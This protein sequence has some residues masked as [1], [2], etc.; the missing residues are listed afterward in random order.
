MTVC[1]TREHHKIR[2]CVSDSGPGIAPEHLPHLWDRFYRV[3]KARSRLLG[4]T[5]LGLAIVKYL[6]E[7]HGGSVDVQ[8][9]PGIGT[10]F[11]EVLPAL[12]GH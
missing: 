2:L 9:A 3:D 11:G 5:G 6:V 4:G 7:A 8:S 10:T 1:V 12:I